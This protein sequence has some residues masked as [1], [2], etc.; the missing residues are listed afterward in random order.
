M[1]E[2]KPKLFYVLPKYEARSATHFSYLVDFLSEMSKTFEIFLL[3]EKG[4]KPEENLGCEKSVVLRS[5]SSVGR[6]GELFYWMLRARFSGWRDF[7]VHYSF[8]G[9]FSA[10]LVVRIFG[11]RVFY[12][13]CGEP[14]KYR[15]SF[16]REFF[17]K[18]TYRLINFLV[19]GSE[20]MA[21]QY[22]RHYKIPLSKTKVMPNWINLSRIDYR[23][24][25]LESEKAKMELGIESGTKILLFVHRLSKRKGA[26]RLPEILEKLKEEKVFLLILG[27]GP[28]CQMI[29]REFEKINLT[30]RVKI[31]GWVP[32]REILKYFALSDIF[33]LPS[34]E[35]GFPHVLLEALALGVPY[36]ANRVGAVEEITPPS[37]KKFL[38]ESENPND[39]SEKV[40]R[41][42]HGSPDEL[43]EIKTEMLAWVWKFDLS[44]SLEKFIQMI[45]R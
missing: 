45:N 26:H 8:A 40:R 23:E 35:E 3:V 6:L 21:K 37:L 32:Q 2:K 9:A 25:N 30:Q 36:A 34:E 38:A 31:I 12:W 5:K 10:S 20:S 24:L 14:W 16:R 19:T 4:E 33:L 27:D 44:K 42:L 41:L 28:E 29:K 43:K 22:S 39:F 11:G 13:N 18:T 15:R 1:T 7:Y 17:E